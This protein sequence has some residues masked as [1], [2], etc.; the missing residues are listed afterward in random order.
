VLNPG[1][2][3]PFGVTGLPQLSL[4]RFVGLATIPNGNYHL[5]VACANANSAPNPNHVDGNNY[6]DV[7]ITICNQTAG[8]SSFN[9][10]VG[11]TTCTPVLPESPLVVALPLS[12]VAIGLGVYMVRRRRVLPA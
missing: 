8:G 2:A 7:P 3:A 11:T 6:W 12:A 9:W 4:Y 10:T 1:A 5:G